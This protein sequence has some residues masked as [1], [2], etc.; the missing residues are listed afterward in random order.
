MK[1]V[2]CLVMFVAGFAFTQD[3]AAGEPEKAF[4]GSVS[5]SGVSKYLW[6][7]WTLH[8]NAAVTP[9]MLLEATRESRH[10]ALYRDIAAK[11]L[12]EEV[13]EQMARAMLA[14][15]L[16]QLER[17]RVESEYRRLAANGQHDEVERQR[18]QVVSR[19]LAEL[20]GAPKADASPVQRGA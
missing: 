19:R 7:G 13:D 4:S 11:S 17:P 20:K 8:D 3:E 16:V 2:M 18:F 1:I 12:G 15:L 5:L 10:A 14:D 9:A 6:R